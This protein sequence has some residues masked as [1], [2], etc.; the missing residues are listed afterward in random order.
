MIS[1]AIISPNL[2]RTAFC[3]FFFCVRYLT[4]AVTSTATFSSPPSLLALFDRLH[5]SSPPPPIHAFNHLFTKIKKSGN[6]YSIFPLYRRLVRKAVVSPDVFTYSIIIDCFRRIG[7]AEMGLA[8]F[9]DM[10][11]RDCS[12]DTVTLSGLVNGLLDAKRVGEAAKMFERMPDWGCT[13]DVVTYCGMIGFFCDVGMMELGLGIFGSMLKRNCPPNTVVFNTLV[14][15]FSKQGLND[16]VKVFSRMMVMLEDGDE[17]FPDL[18]T[19][20]TVIHSCCQLG[21][22][23]FGFGVLGSMLKAGCSPSIITITSLVNGLCITDRVAEA[24]FLF[25][26]MSSELSITPDVLSYGALINGFCH[27][28]DVE[29]AF[30]YLG[31][32]LKCGY[33][34]TQ[35]ILSELVNGLCVSGR[36]LDASQ[37]IEKMHECDVVTYSTLIKGFCHV[38]KT[39]LAIEL[40]EVMKSLR[41]DDR[42]RPDAITYNTIIDHLCRIG[43]MEEASGLLDDMIANNISPT[44]LT[45]RSLMSGYLVLGQLNSASELQRRMDGSV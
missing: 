18:T 35:V 41:V 44:N 24:S 22:V 4:T 14:N 31:L 5:Y 15:G 16:L 2:N 29:L 26:L 37:M 21:H 43:R 42:R 7:R 36:V 38:G 20:N 6:Y 32:M 33:H 28:G 39:S 13:P 10:F 30:G 17:C 34:P 27:K 40:L 19:F 11:K 9:G 8:I 1:T 12:P 45:F 23:E 3:S 25:N